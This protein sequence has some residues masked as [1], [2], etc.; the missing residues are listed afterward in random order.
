M[1][2]AKYYK[3]TQNYKVGQK[4]LKEGQVLQSGAKKILKRGRYY[5]VG[6]NYKVG[7][8]SPSPPSDPQPM[9]DGISLQK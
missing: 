5:K 7:H 3:D 1:I 9:Y 6:Q 4:N 2:P 8:P